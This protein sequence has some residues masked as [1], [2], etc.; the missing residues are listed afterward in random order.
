M[1]TSVNALEDG[2]GRTV[3]LMPMTAIPQLVNMEEP[4]W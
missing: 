3:V 4:V 1:D 2:R